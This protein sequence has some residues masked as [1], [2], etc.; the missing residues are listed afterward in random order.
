VI[1]SLLEG[2]RGLSA[3][4]FERFQIFLYILS[5]LFPD[6]KKDKRVVMKNEDKQILVL[7]GNFENLKDVNKDKLLIVG[8][9]LLNVKE[10]V[11]NEKFKNRGIF[12]EVRI[13]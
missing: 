7:T 5:G 12:F 9:K 3:I 6:R 2:F 4:I 13:S 8:K 1:K 11:M 10:L